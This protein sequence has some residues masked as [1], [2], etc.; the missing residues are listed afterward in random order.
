MADETAVQ[1]FNTDFL[2]DTNKLNEFKITFNNR[3]HDLLTRSTE[4]KRNYYVGQLERDQSSINFNVSAGGELQEASSHVM[5]PH[6]NPSQDSRKEEPERLIKDSEGKMIAEIQEQRD[7]MAE[8]FQQL[9]NR[10][11]LLR[12]P[13]PKQHFQTLLYMSLHQRLNKSRWPSDKCRVGNH[14]DMTIY[15]PKC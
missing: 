13:V 1:W 15:K 5:D 11:A 4:R 14:Q 12:P 7:R 8:N 9:L 10:P 3:F 2:R 6:Q